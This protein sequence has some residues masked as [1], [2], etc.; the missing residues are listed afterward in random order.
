MKNT[1]EGINLIVIAHGWSR[2]GISY[3]VSSFR[4]A[5]VHDERHLSHYEDVY[6]NVT[7]EELNRLEKCH[8]HM[9]SNH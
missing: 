8:F 7:S 9:R 1:I 3:L 6:E 5:S 4:S 2:R